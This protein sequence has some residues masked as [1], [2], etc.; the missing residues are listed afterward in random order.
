MPVRITDYG[1]VFYMFLFF[2]KTAGCD[3]ES[4]RLKS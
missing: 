3:F 4:H 1:F 2:K